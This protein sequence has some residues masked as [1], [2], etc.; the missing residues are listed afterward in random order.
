MSNNTAVAQVFHKIDKRFTKLYKIKVYTHHYKE[1]ID[2]TEFEDAIQEI[3]D[4][5][6]DYKDLE[7]SEYEPFEFEDYQRTF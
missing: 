5:K 2:D 3:R 4:I 7:I 6:E 1:F